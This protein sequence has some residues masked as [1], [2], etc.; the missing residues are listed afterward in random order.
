M[1]EPQNLVKMPSIRQ[2]S[3]FECGQF[4]RCDAAFSLVFEA[5]RPEGLEPSTYGLEIRCSIRLSYGRIC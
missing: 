5:A 4:S 2:V 1:F 3:L